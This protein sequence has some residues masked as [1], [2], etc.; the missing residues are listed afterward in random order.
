MRCGEDI[1][2]GSQFQQTEAKREEIG[3]CHGWLCLQQSWALWGP[4]RMPV[5]LGFPVSLSPSPTHCI[6]HL[7]F[8]LGTGEPVATT[9]SLLSGPKTQSL[10]AGFHSKALTS[11]RWVT[12]HPRTNQAGGWRSLIGQQQPALL[13]CWGGSQVVGWVWEGRFTGARL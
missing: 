7:H 9:A 6:S 12:G 10:P 4:R 13:L 5:S 8:P 11:V 3:C 1:R 2:W